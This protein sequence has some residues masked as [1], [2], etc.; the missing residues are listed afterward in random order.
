MTLPERKNSPLP[1]Q[2]KFATRDSEFE[3]I[4]EL[5]Y[6]TF[7]EEIPQYEPVV[8][9]RLIDKFHAE[10]TY[11][12]CLCGRELVGMLAVR[13]QRP[14][15]LDEKLADL[16]SYLSAGRSVCEVR[17]LSVEKHFRSRKVL[18]G[19][20]ALLWQFFVQKGYDLAVISGILG[21]AKLYRH[22]GFTAFGPVV[23][24]GRVLFRPMFLTLETFEAR[25][26][27]FLGIA[28][29]RAGV[30]ATV[31]SLP[32]PVLA[33]PEQLR[34]REPEPKH[35]QGGRRRGPRSVANRAVGGRSHE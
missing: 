16:D 31:N 35:R 29:A 30:A 10:N 34:C 2:F 23:G 12:I 13:G 19:L 33:L 27:E 26:M 4:H 18:R 9:H 8:S 21:Q 32:E 25:A 1:L 6:K 15:S 22:L 14:F 5:N 17:L 20:L 28:P 3:L 7:V 24:T 11:L